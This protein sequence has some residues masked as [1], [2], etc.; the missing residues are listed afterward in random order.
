MSLEELRNLAAEKESELESCRKSRNKHQVEHAS[1]QEYYNVTQEQIR[2]LEMKIDKID[3][4]IQNAE[5]DN[6]TELKVY[7]QKAKFIQYCHDNKIKAAAEEDITKQQL[8]GAYQENH[9]SELGESKK[10][11]MSQL[12]QIEERHAREIKN[13]QADIDQEL[14]QIRQNLDS[15]VECFEQDCKKQHAQLKEELEAKH[16]AELE[17]VSSRKESH[18]QDLMQSHETS[19]REMSDYFDDIERQQEIEMEELQME[20]RRLKKAAIHHDETKERLEKS[21]VDNSKELDECMQQ[22]SARCVFNFASLENSYHH[23]ILG[24][25]FGDQNQRLR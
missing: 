25:R 20:I 13:L 10:E 4:D 15:E 1:L 7:K 18:M 17:I 3:L 12:R 19:C 21:N 6:I 22:V 8:Y 14:V 9:L 11:M 2:E 16:K 23:G 5:E 24:C